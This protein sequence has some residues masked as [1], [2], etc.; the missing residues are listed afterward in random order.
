MVTA[1]G[2]FRRPASTVPLPPYLFRRPPALHRL[3]STI[4]VTL[5][6]SLAR[7]QFRI[8]LS[9]LRRVCPLGNLPNH[10]HRHNEP[11]RSPRYCPLR[12][13]LVRHRAS[14]PAHKTHM[15]FPPPLPHRTPTS[16]VPHRTPFHSVP[17]SLSQSSPIPSHPFPRIW[18]LLFLRPP[19]LPSL[20]RIST[21]PVRRPQLNQSGL[22]F[23]Q[24]Q[25]QSQLRITLLLG[26]PWVI[27]PHILLGFCDLELSTITATSSLSSD[28]HIG[29]MLA[30]SPSFAH[31]MLQDRWQQQQH[32]QAIFS[33][34]QPVFEAH[35]HSASPAP[36]VPDNK[37]REL[38]SMASLAN[39]PAAPSPP[40]PASHAQSPPA[41]FPDP[42]CAGSDSLCAQF[43]AQSP[44]DG[45][46]P[47]LAAGCNEALPSPIPTPP[48]TC[49]S[50]LPAGCATDPH[51]P[52]VKYIGVRLR[53]RNR[54][55]AEIK[56][57]NHGVRKWLGTFACPV[58]A[59]QAFDAAA[60]AIRGP[61]TKANFK[62]GDAEFVEDVPEVLSVL[63]YCASGK[64]PQSS[65]AN[66]AGSAD[67]FARRTSPKQLSPAGPPGRRPGRGKPPS[68]SAGPLPLA[69]GPPSIAAPSY[70]AAPYAVNAT[71][72][73]ATL[74]HAAPRL[75]MPSPSSAL[76]APNPLQLTGN[77]NADASPLTPFPCARAPHEIVVK[78]EALAPSS[79]LPVAAFAEARAASEHA[80]IVQPAHAGGRAV[81]GCAPPSAVDGVTWM[82]AEPEQASPWP[83]R[84]AESD[85]FPQLVAPAPHAP[86]HSPTTQWRHAQGEQR[87]VRLGKRRSPE[88][89]EGLQLNRLA[90]NADASAPAGM[91]GVLSLL[92]VGAL[93]SSGERLGGRLGG[94]SLKVKGMSL[95]SLLP[96]AEP[97]LTPEEFGELRQR[98]GWKVVRMEDLEEIPRVAREALLRFRGDKDFTMLSL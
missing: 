48:C 12:S 51:A 7:D 76:V 73:G 8:L 34:P 92:S 39:H 69:I 97:A 86:Y 31:H 17:P 68:P 66:L 65:A 64:P 33:S 40:P 74:H 50:R 83:T 16:P 52:T 14:S 18:F 3:P 87:E 78:R 67:G 11:A 27:C 63:A 82:V 45:P 98:L 47:R 55:V 5:S 71:Q 49:Y 77:Y 28:R 90:R 2:P 80:V 20:R 44:P 91:G 24:T 25:S 32:Q 43:A 93:Q 85:R 58:Q 6:S 13:L 37:L 10:T 46:P 1:H 96:V 94:E 81:G 9:W 15:S 95:S 56:D 29:I 21:S 89:A 19:T 54:W 4:V 88:P 26:L 70:A 84:T 22:L 75:S 62:R 53:G 35:H 36:G 79:L 57:N 41:A 60:R 61:K 23:P 30:A 59:A 42:W 38:A 72:A